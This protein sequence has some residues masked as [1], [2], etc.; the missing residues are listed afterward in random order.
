MET[1]LMGVG[2]MMVTVGMIAALDRLLKRQEGL[3]LAGNKDN[4]SEEERN[5]VP[6]QHRAN[7]SRRRTIRTVPA[8]RRGKNHR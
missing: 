7:G 3:G 5:S 1:I 2:E 4:E 6:G 8:I